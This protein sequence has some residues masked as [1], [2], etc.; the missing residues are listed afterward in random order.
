M[1]YHPTKA[2]AQDAAEE[3]WLFEERIG[4]YAVQLVPDKGWVVVV[5]P[6]SGAKDLS[7][8]A[9]QVEIVRNGRWSWR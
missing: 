1:I 6:V 9:N 3:M 7:D 2:A 5:L 4:T 8:L